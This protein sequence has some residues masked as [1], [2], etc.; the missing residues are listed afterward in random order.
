M[1]DEIVDG[2]RQPRRLLEQLR[3]WIHDFVLENEAQLQEYQE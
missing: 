1:M 2:K 3:K